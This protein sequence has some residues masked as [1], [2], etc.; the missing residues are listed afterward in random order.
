M[1]IVILV[2]VVNIKLLLC[3]QLILKSPKPFSGAKTDD[4]NLH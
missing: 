2:D 3:I 4:Q 1:Y